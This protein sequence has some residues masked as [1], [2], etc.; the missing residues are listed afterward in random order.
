M[1]AHIAYAREL[2]ASFN[3]ISPFTLSKGS[4]KYVAHQSTKHAYWTG[5][6]ATRHASPVTIFS[7]ELAWLKHQLHDL[8]AVGIET[9]EKLL[10][11]HLFE[12][13]ADDSS[14]RTRED[15]C[16]HEYKELVDSH[17][18]VNGF[19]SNALARV[20]VPNSNLKAMYIV[21]VWKNSMDSGDAILQATATY[22]A[23]ILDEPVS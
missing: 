8:L 22:A 17:L 3:Q 20:L 16:F 4:S 19:T 1:S 23:H 5:R 2:R 7:P 11:S 18:E 15:K 21:D 9:H 14:E 12:A 13:M 10:V 6:P